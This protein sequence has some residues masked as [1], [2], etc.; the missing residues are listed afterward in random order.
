MSAG[1]TDAR[2]SSAMAGFGASAHRR[3]TM[4]RGLAFLFAA[5]G[6]LVALSLV[7]PH[8]ANTDEWAPGLA[9]VA[10][11]LVAAGLLAA[12]ERLGRR[13]LSLV[14][15]GGTALITVCVLGGGDSATAYML[16]YVWVALYAFY[17]LPRPWALGHML[18]VAASFAVALATVDAV[19]APAIHWLMGVGTVVVAGI[20][21]GAL[22]RAL[23][24]QSADLATVAEMAGGLTDDVRH[25]EATCAALR[26][27]TAAD[28]ALMLEAGGDDAALRTVA[29]VGSQDVARTLRHG[30]AL[31]AC[32]T[33]LRTAVPVV[34][35]TD[36]RPRGWRRF[37]STACGL[38]QPV[39]RD[40]AAVGLL[41]VGWERAC[42]RG[43]S[44]R[45]R[46][47]A[48]LFASEASVAMERAARASRDRERRAL[49]INDEI[50][51]GLVVAK[52]AV[53]AGRQET[54]A[55][56]L[57]E[58]LE[59]ARRLMTEQ[60]EGVLEGGGEIRPGDLTR[61]TGPAQAGGAGEAGEAAAR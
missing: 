25:P 48:L 18:L 54:G 56:V 9:A 24:D 34:I 5:G 46:T 3:G 10:A 32:R 55:R 7:L 19:P 43:I 44:D 45:V 12:P 58:T 6:L 21:I 51:Q 17:F 15:A 22:T 52:Y 16:M 61:G 40:G 33:A 38:A 37:G 60:L 28:V 35:D 50:V 49:E 31:E 30:G 29:A 23:R 26:H 13:G 36:E 11:L 39:L 41:V 20:L 27:S 47:A 4:A 1:G 8:A 2:T 53:E 42:A 14:L 57:Q 59:R